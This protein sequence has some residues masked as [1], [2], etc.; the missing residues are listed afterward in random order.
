[1]KKVAEQNDE[2]SEEE[3][4]KGAG[5]KAAD[6][7]SLQFF[8]HSFFIESSFLP[9]STPFSSFEEITGFLQDLI[10]HQYFQ[11]EFKFLESL[12]VTIP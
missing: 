1:M 4:G 7:T 8:F 10:R 5:K 2:E 11:V 3:E 6:R 12:A 9:S